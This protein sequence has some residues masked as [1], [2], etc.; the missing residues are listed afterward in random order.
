MS[1][2]CLCETF[3]SSCFWRERLLVVGTVHMSVRQYLNE[4]RPQITLNMF[5]FRVFRP[6]NDRDDGNVPQLGQNFKNWKF[7]CDS[8]ISIQ[9]LDSQ[10][11]GLT[12]TAQTVIP[13]PVRGV[14][15]DRCH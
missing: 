10:L 5:D 1:K 7:V 14:Y 11:P 6:T 15:P 13:D 9:R 12:N 3:L 2:S 4:Q 8:E